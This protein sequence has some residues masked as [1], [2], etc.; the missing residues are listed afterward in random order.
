MSLSRL[1]RHLSDASVRDSVSGQMPE[2]P[3]HGSMAVAGDSDAIF[4]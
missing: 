4:I 2:A 3:N 1:L